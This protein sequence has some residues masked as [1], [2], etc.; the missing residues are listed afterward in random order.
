MKLKEYAM[1]IAKLAK[2]H[3]NATMVFSCDEEGNQYSPVQFNPTTG[4]YEFGGTGG[5]WTPNDGTKEFKVTA[6]CV[7]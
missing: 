2:K 7:N 6:V 5:E 3:P 1:Y 4:A